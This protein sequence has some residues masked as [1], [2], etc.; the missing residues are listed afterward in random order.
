MYMLYLRVLLQFFISI[1]DIFLLTEMDGKIFIV[2]ITIQ[3]L[4]VM[5]LAG[6]SKVYN[7]INL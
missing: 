4:C 6:N 1:M 5:C 7:I 2:F 3:T